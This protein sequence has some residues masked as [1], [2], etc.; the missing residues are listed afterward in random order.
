MHKLGYNY[1]GNQGQNFF[2]VPEDISKVN[3]LNFSVDPDL[4]QN[5]NLIAASS[6]NNGKSNNENLKALIALRNSTDIFTTTKGTPDDFVKSLLSAL[7]VDSSQ[8]KR[9]SANSETLIAQTKNKIYSESGVS[10][11]EEMS[12]MVKFQQTYNASARLIT[13]L[14]Q[15]LDTMIN[16]LG[17]VGR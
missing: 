16:R 12:N 8:A 13:S 1:D 2:S 3:C 10:L 4:L 17:L 11:D 5:P 6:S 15:I 14:D 7:A 9:M